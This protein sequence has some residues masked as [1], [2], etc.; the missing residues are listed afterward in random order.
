[1][2]STLATCSIKRNKTNKNKRRQKEDTTKQKR[3]QCHFFGCIPKNCYQA[4]TFSTHL[5]PSQPGPVTRHLVLSAERPALLV[6]KISHQQEPLCRTRQKKADRSPELS[7]YGH[8]TADDNRNR[9][10]LCWTIAFE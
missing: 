10:K 3:K 1:M 5:S 7:H 2:L 6:S 9:L 4:P 8:E